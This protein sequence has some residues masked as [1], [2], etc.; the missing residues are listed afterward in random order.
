M[1]PLP[2]PKAL[3]ETFGSPVATVAAPSFARFPHLVAI[4]TAR[5]PT[6]RSVVVSE[7]G[8]ASALARNGRLTI[9]MI[10]DATT[11]PAGSRL[12]LTLAGSS[13]DLLYAV[14]VPLGSRLTVTSVRLSIPVLRRPISG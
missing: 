4:L 11:I 5:T 8:A 10:A 3:I 12:Q 2:R 6:G 7:G 14:G 1:R 9:R 13:T